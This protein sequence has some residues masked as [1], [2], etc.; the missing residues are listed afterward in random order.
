[1]VEIDGLGKFG[2]ELGKGKWGTPTPATLPPIPAEARPPVEEKPLTLT[3]EQAEKLKSI[4][5]TIAELPTAIRE[6]LETRELRNL[7]REIA[8]LEKKKE[9]IEK[10]KALELQREE[11][12]KKKAELEKV[13]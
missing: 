1:M 13:V 9:Y 10:K 3:T 12:L 8:E 5:T 7:E 11:L 2:E 6:R 4:I